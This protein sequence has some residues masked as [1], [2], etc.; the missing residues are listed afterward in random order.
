MSL[1]NIALL[2]MTSCGTDQAANQAK[3]EAFCRQAKLLGADVA[4]FPE[5]WSNGYAD[6]DADRPDAQEAIHA[7]AVGPEDSFVQH[8]RA[9]AKELDLAIAVTYLEKWPGAPR[10][11]VSLIDR[12]G[13]IVLT[14]AKVHLCAWDGLEA[15]LTPGDEFFVC[16]LDTAQ[17]VVKVGAMI[18]FDREYPESARVLMLKG[19]EIIL[20]PNACTMDAPRLG[21]FR[22]RA[23]ENMLGVALANYAAPQNNGH[24]VA[25]DA[26]AYQGDERP[27]DT[28]LVEAGEGE[29][30]Y[31]AAF[32]LD[33]LRAWR[34]S[35]VWGNAFRRPRAYGLLTSTDVQPP[36]VRAS[37]RR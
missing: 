2:Q 29:G 36:F 25:Y 19:A 37:S 22:A 32:D 34:Q 21:Q 30:V 31:L 1:L 10:N 13:E 17:G 35:E 15:N 8:F 12:R 33:R 6:L 3:G 14:Y 23:M 11:T 26:M 7:Q 16:D 20:T 28:L 5:M 9:L 24:S 27:R 4:L 18:C